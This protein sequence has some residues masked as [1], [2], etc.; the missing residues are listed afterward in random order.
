MKEAFTF[1][2]G[3]Q[4]KHAVKI[5]RKQTSKDELGNEVLQ[6]HFEH[7]INVWKCLSNRYILPLLSVIDTPYA[8]W[9][10]TLLFSGGTL[11]DIFKN[12]RQGLPPSLALKYS[13]QLASALRYLHQDAYVV[14]R[15]VKLENCVLDRPASEGGNLRLCDFGLA[16]FLPGDDT[17]PPRTD[18]ITPSSMIEEKQHLRSEDMVAGGSL[19]YAAPEQ[20]KSI[21]PLLDPAI[22]MWSYGVVVH[23]LTV[24]ELPFHDP[25][26]P[27]LQM[28]ILKGEWNVERCAAR[29][30]SEICEIIT[31]CL[32]MNRGERWTAADVLSSQW[33]SLHREDSC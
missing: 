32:K 8:T 28:M 7:E 23:A 6:S 21:T 2:N 9:A 19:A 33:I 13:Y 27:K 24:G 15:D 3:R 4:V 18:L 16:D 31:G 30:D 5:V 14:H 29:V 25:F 17:P 1:Q 20:I 11:F 26:A 12:Y 10:F 22:D